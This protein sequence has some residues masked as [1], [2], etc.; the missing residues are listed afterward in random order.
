VPEAAPPAQ[1][2]ILFDGICNLCNG[3]VDFVTRR[4]PKKRFGFVAMQ[5]KAGI[6]FL[7]QR[8]LP[9]DTMKGLYLIRGDE[10]HHKSGAV[11]RILAGLRAP[12]PL[13]AVCWI[14]PVLIRDAAYDFVAA[15]RYRWFGK[16][17]SF[18]E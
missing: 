12:W 2:L 11:L 15:R 3:W 5:S 9:A 6:R 10:V 17:E 16:K 8:G 7:E 14:V 13:V 1:D 18:T 4:D